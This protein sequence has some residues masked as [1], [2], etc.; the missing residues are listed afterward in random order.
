LSNGNPLKKFELL[1]EKL[2][3]LLQDGAHAKVG[4][5]NGVGAKLKVYEMK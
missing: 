5:D 3:G 2:V 4:K 1:W